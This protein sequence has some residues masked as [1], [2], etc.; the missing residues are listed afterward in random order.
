MKIKPDIIVS[1]DG[2]GNYKYVKDAIAE[3]PENSKEKRFVIYI[4][5]GI[6][7]ENVIIG[8]AKTNL[9]IVGD[10]SDTTIIIGSLNYG[11]DHIDIMHSAMLATETIGFMAQDICFQN[12]ARPTKGQA[13]ALRVSADMSV[14]YRCCIDW[15]QDTL[16]ADKGRQLY[17]DCLIIVTIDF[18][19]GAAAA[20]FQMCD[21]LARKPGS[22]NDNVLTAQGR[23]VASITNSCF[24][25]Q[26]CHIKAS[27]DLILVKRTV[28]TFLGHPWKSLS[29]VV[30]MQCFIDDLV[31]PAGWDTMGDDKGRLSTLYY[32][33]YENSNPG[34]D[35][36]KMVKWKG[37]KVITVAKLIRGDLCLKPYGVPYQA[38]L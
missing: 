26:N 35:T 6:Y 23:D 16:L 3:V 33:E 27:A 9:T 4:K 38:G 7:H 24:T 13:V 15:Y 5:K 17:R 21:I 18:I 20:V 22:G 2:T 10:G 28:K 36:S 31:D 12:T 25:L 11:V 14:I 29:R 19:F 34:A 30:V 8:Q 32:G 1:Q 37:H